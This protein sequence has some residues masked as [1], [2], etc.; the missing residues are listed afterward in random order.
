MPPVTREQT[1][2]PG[3]PARIDPSHKG[4]TIVDTTEPRS[5]EVQLA[6]DWLAARLLRGLDD[7]GLRDLITKENRD[8]A[9]AALIATA[10]EIVNRPRPYDY[11]VELVDGRIEIVQGE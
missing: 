4:P 2:S 3:N 6:L 11:H 10:E 1:A 7:A 5:E 9:S 8:R